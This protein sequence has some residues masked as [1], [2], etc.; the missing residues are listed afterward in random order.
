MDNE[1]YK[2]VLKGSSWRRA[3]CHRTSITRSGS[4]MSE[5]RTDYYGYNDRSKL[6]NVAK[7]VRPFC[8]KNISKLRLYL[9]IQF[10]CFLWGLTIGI[11]C[12]KAGF[13]RVYVCALVSV[14][15]VV[16]FIMN[17]FVNKYAKCPECGMSLRDEFPFSYP[18]VFVRIMFGGIVKCKH[19]Q[20]NKK[21]YAIGN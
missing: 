6:T 17:Y 2:T 12:V 16:A 8:V 18:D 5:T 20:R 13:N 11:I 4:M 10:G 21:G 7:R 19:K 3:V 9:W 15:S 1:R 14:F